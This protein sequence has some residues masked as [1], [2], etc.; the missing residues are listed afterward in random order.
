MTTDELTIDGAQGEGGGQ[1]LRSALSLSLVTGRP[2]RLVGVRAG[3]PT[4]G[5]LR[6]HLAAVRAAAAV[7]RAEVEGAELG[8]GA[9]R[10][11]PRGLVPGDHA[12]SVGGAGSATLVLQTV[13][14]ALMAAAGPSRVTVEGGTHNP[15]APPYDAIERSFL[16]LLAR[17]GA[18]V[19]TTLERRGY[20]PAG[21]GRLT[22]AVEPGTAAVPLA[23]SARGAVRTRR[24]TVLLANLPRRIAAVEEATL[25]RLLPADLWTIERVTEE[26]GRGPGNVV[27]LDVACEHVHEVFAA[28][29]MRELRADAV[30]DEA[31]G[32]YREWLAADVPVGPHLADQLLL[33]LALGAGGTFRTVAPT[34]HTKTNADV[35]RQFLPDV[36]IDLVADGA[37]TTVTVARR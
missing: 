4:P 33:P 3:R 2:F 11:A 22:A 21:G 8:S 10:F 27:L 14:P 20:F 1:I 28:F 24:A 34:R 36:R 12:F 25:R 6:Q 26:D 5:L 23:L 17:V 35:I 31:V 29:G 7:G 9:L 30:V 32:A 15:W 13:L 37:A 19:T 16:P 18:R